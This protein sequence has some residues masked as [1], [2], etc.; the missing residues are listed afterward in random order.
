MLKTQLFTISQLFFIYEKAI[1][2]SVKQTFD[3]DSFQSVEDYYKDLVE[4]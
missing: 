1:S 2:I 3:A 4:T